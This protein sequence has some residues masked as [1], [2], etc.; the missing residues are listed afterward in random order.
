[1]TSRL[2]RLKDLQTQLHFLIEKSK[3]NY[4]QVTSKLSDI[5]QV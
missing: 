2:N 5:G 1:M 3:E 4:S